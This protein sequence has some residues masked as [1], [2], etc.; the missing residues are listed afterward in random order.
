[1]L[2]HFAHAN[3]IPSASY[4]PLFEK[5]APHSV[6]AKP[7]FGHDSHYPFTKNWVYMA[8]ELIDYL[9]LNAQ[10]PVLAVGHSMGALVSFIAACK[11]PELFKGVLML[12]PPLIFGLGSWVFRA[13][14][15]TGQIDK[16]TPAGKSKFRRSQ[17]PDRQ[18]AIDYFASKPLFQFESSC[19]DAFCHSALEE[20][21]DGSVQLA[22]KVEVELGIF[23]NTPHNLKRYNPSK[24][25]PIKVV[26]GKQSDASR[27][28]FII[29]FCEYFDIPY[30]QIDGQHMYPL[31]QPDKTVEIIQSFVSEID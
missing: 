24:D 29:P 10:Q 19:F 14:K 13:A 21:A 15:L 31:Q 7:M 3:G 8:D 6:I 17:W 30:E 22:Y 5:L 20:A 28:H 26:F 18:A 27:G 2:I 23:R 11:K 12:D 16:I 4:S 25:I 1:M 9:D